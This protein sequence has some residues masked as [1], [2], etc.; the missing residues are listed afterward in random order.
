MHVV[1]REPELV[2]EAVGSR[3][4]AVDVELDARAARLVPS[5]HLGRGPGRGLG[6]TERHRPVGL[7]FAGQGHEHDGSG[8]GRGDEGPEPAET[9]D[10][11]EWSQ[12]RRSGVVGDRR[13]DR[14]FQ[15]GVRFHPQRIVVEMQPAVCD[16]TG[17]LGPRPLQ[18]DVVGVVV[19]G[20]VVM[21]LMWSSSCSSLR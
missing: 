6:G 16:Q 19:V 12:V 10:R 3:A 7:G 8:C 17:D 1:C 18:V 20:H 2:D 15:I 9:T 5:R 11:R 14:R 21:S 4:E 13:H